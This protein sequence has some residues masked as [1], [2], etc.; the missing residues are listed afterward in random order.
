RYD[1]TV[2]RR[3]PARRC[4]GGIMPSDSNR[5]KFLGTAAGVA[6]FTIL[7]RHVLARSGEVPPSDKITLAY[8][9]TGTQGLRE[10]MPMLASPEIQVDSVCDPCKNAT[11]Y[12]DWSRDSLLRD[13]R[14]GLNKLDWRSGVKGTVPG[15]RDVGKSVVDT[16]YGNQGCSAYADYRE[17]LEKEKDL[18]AVKIMTPDHL[19]G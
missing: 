9:G 3:P 4:W 10:L 13:I 15:G 17:L 11:G 12:R 6:A 14:R 5:R 7:P 16:F 19:H 1:T 18:N 2:P 8:I